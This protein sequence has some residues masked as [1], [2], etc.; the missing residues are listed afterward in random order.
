MAS[1]DRRSFLLGLS[2]LVA[3]PAIVRTTSL[4]PVLDPW[5][6]PP[7]FVADFQRDFDAVADGVSCNLAAMERARQWA[8][9]RGGGCIIN[10][11]DGTYADTEISGKWPNHMNFIGHDSVFIARRN[12]V[13]LIINADISYLTI[14]YCEF[15]GKLEGEFDFA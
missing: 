2:T 9:C 5:R 4:M 14:S 8:T 11:G 15:R 7:G 12:K 3:A 6:G 13:A 1:T 10:W